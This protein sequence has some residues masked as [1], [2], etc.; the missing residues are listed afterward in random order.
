MLTDVFQETVSRFPDR[1]AVTDMAE[2]FTWSALHACSSRL[3]ARLE[4]EGI[5]SGDTVAL[6]LSNSP[7]FIA[8]FIA[9]IGRGSTVLPVAPRLTEAELHFYFGQGKV[10]GVLA[11]PDT[12]DRCR[13]VLERLGAGHAVVLVPDPDSS[14]AG[15]VSMPSSEGAGADAGALMQFSSGSTGR[16]K[17]LVRTHRHCRAEADHFVATTGLNEQDT[18]FCPVPL[19]H[20]HGLGNGLLA[21]VRSGARLLLF[22]D[23]QPFVLKRR[24]AL[25]LLE[26][27]R[28]TFFAGVPMLFQALAEAPETADL[29]ALRLAFSAGTALPAS[30]FTAFLE[31]FG[32][33]VRQL[34]GCTEAG[35]ISINLDSDLNATWNSVGRPM[36]GITL[37]IVD[38]SGAPV[39]TGTMGE[40]FVR[41][42][43]LAT[44]Y[45]DDAEATARSFR[46]EGFFT[47]DLGR[48]DPA[49]RLYL[50]GR[51]RL[52]IEREGFKV[53]P[54]E[55]E[56][57]LAAHPG[58]REAVVVG[59][60]AGKPGM[61]ALKAVVVPLA[62]CT[63]AD[64]I[65]YCQS[66]LASYKVPQEVEFRDAMPRSPLGKILRD[67]LL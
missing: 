7:I 9:A 24:R 58:V 19:H 27:E 63:E 35:S 32:V 18:I 60:P 53:D 42:P 20:A 50:T 11:E 47:G 29:S 54:V 6:A 43:A 61:N 49:G 36:Q 57:V 1:V 15:P 16:P 45:A 34:Y 28:A 10:R 21:S 51:K 39:S 52:F 4:A 44:G 64:L 67:Q 17:R 25:E 3:G 14:V 46:N 65:R 31:R 59:I 22:K 2:T 23:P 12:A 41:S 48:L 8:A 38:E 37:E 30:T 40:V 33:P 26:S 13:L 56:E 62:P 5:G 55:V 66:R